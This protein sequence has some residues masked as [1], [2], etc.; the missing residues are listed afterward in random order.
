MS[1]KQTCG[2]LLPRLPLH[3]K[4]VIRDVNFNWDNFFIGQTDVSLTKDG[5]GIFNATKRV[6]EDVE[7]E[8]KDFKYLPDREP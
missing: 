7:L 4:V 3:Y 8:V 1:T 5:V 2:V 6:I